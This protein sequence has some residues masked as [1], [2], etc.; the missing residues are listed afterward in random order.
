MTLDSIILASSSVISWS[1]PGDI[2]MTSEDL[3]QHQFVSSLVCLH[4]KATSPVGTH[5]ILVSGMK[6]SVE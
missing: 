5:Y 4:H 1:F 2:F 6:I 3:S